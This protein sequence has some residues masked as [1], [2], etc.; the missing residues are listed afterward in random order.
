MVLK[1][2]H[3]LV[4]H[5]SHESHSPLAVV[6]E[7]VA[8]YLVLVE[9]LCQQLAYDEENLGAR[10]VEREAAGVCHHA[11]V[12]LH[13]LFLR[14]LLEAAH[15]PYH[16][17]QH[18]ARAAQLGMRHA[19]HG[20]DVWLGVMVYH[21]FLCRRCRQQRTH[22]ASQTVGAVEVETEHQFGICHSVLHG[23][24]MLVVSHYRLRLG[25]PLQE[26]GIGIGHRY[27]G[28]LAILLQIFSQ[29]QR[30]TEGIAIGVLVATY[31]NLVRLS[32][33]VFQQ[34]SLFFFQYFYMHSDCKDTY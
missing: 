20:V 29:R 15:L 25:Q 9:A 28:C 8:V 30:R 6:V 23:F 5:I 10:R 14:H 16:P 32:Y 27:S 33:Q 26:V 19:Q 4:E 13:C 11:A 31:Y 1:H 3:L 34:G 24:L 21:H 2:A 18:L 22:V 12:N 17:E 7:H